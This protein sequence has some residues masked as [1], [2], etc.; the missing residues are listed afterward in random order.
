[1]PIKVDTVGR[2]R[3]SL[4]LSLSRDD[5][6]KMGCAR[7]TLRTKDLV[8]YCI[9]DLDARDRNHEYSINGHYS[10]AKFTPPELLS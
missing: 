1:M 8:I 9:D 3:S 2:M 5:R 10:P 7:C 4:S 6:Q